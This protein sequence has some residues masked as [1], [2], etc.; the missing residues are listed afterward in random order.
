M[1]A[2]IVPMLAYAAVVQY[3]ARHS[4]RPIVSSLVVVGI[5]T[6]Y[7]LVIKLI[8]QSQFGIKLAYV[9]G[10]RDVAVALVQIVVAY[11]IFRLL[12]HYEETYVTW[13]FLAIVGAVLLLAI[14]PAVI[15]QF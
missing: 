7:V 3:S 9:F 2:M 4:W 14:V 15:P 12:E 13:F 10:F 5:H 11:V 6:S 8:M 1:Y